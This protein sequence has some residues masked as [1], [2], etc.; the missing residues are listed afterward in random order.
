MGQ[1]Y[2]DTVAFLYRLERND[3]RLYGVCWVVLSAIT[4]AIRG[5]F[6]NSYKQP[7]MAPTYGDK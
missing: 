1:K 7:M 3:N 6:A 5:L 4:A 2:A